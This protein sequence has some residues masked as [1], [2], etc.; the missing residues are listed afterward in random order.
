M[1]LSSIAVVV[2]D[3]FASL[4]LGMAAPIIVFV[5]EKYLADYMPKG[6]SVDAIV[7][8]T[9]GGILNSI[10]TAG[11]SSRSPSIAE[12]A[13]TQGGYQFA[14]LIVTICLSGLMGL[15]AAFILRCFNPKQSANKDNSMWFIDQ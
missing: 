10:I 8:C 3:P 12:N 4:L 15:F 13:Y 5:M 1:F 7:L 11:R 14:T 9:L 6:Y 2:I